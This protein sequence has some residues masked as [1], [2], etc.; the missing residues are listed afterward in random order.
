M[1]TVTCL[2]DMVAILSCLI[3]ITYKLLK[4]AHY[5][6]ATVQGR[7]NGVRAAGTWTRATKRMRSGIHR[8]SPDQ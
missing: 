7:L 2:S 8:A 5:T 6:G 4:I 3:I 1:S